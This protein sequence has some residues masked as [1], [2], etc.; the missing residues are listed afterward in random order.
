M[1]WPKMAFDID[2]CKPSGEYS[3]VAGMRREAPLGGE[4]P[5]DGNGS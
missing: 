3:G 2:E 4:F 5:R 1:F